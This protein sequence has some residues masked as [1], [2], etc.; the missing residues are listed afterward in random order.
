MNSSYFGRPNWTA[1]L[2]WRQRIA[3]W[4]LR[5]DGL[6]S[7]G[8]CCVVDA[9]ALLDLC[10]VADEGMATPESF[11]LAS[12]TCLAI[13]LKAHR[14]QERVEDIVGKTSSYHMAQVV[15][16]ER[17][18]AHT[19]RAVTFEGRVHQAV[20]DCSAYGLLQVMTKLCPHA[21]GQLDRI[22]ELVR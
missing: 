2:V 6:L 20:I 12:I 14:K 19:F 13:A 17:R 5:A 16:S 10:M 3:E 1:R 15:E 21:R 8:Y 4:M 7:I 22:K 11:Q 18:M 9:L